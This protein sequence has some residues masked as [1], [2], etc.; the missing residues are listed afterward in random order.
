MGIRRL[1]GNSKKAALSSVLVNKLKD[2]N[3]D[4][5]RQLRC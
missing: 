4:G 2:P 3:Y 5:A 1:F